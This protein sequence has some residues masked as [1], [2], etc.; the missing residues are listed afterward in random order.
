MKQFVLFFAVIFFIFMTISVN[1]QDRFDRS[2][3]IVCD[4]L[5]NGGMG[6]IVSGVDFDNDG[7]ME[8]YMVNNNWNDLLGHEQVP[9]IYKYEK[10]ENGEWEVVWSTRLPLNYQNTWP[11]LD[12]GD[13]D[14]DGKM[15]VIWGP[16][17]ND[18]SGLQPVQER[19]LVFETPGDG[20]DN[21]GVQDPAT[22]YWRPNA[23]WTITTTPLANIRPFRWIVADVD[24][25]GTQEIVAECRAGDFMQIYSVD[26][27]PDAADSTETWTLEFS[28]GTSDYGDLAIIGN[29]MYFMKYLTGD[30]IKVVATA[31]NT[32]EIADTLVGVAG[33][34]TWKS[35]ATV[36]VD[37][38]GT[39][40][41]ILVSYTPSND[42]YLLQEDGDTLIST[43]IKDV[44]TSSNRSQG[45]AAG[46]LDDDGNLDFVFGTRQS[47]PLGIIH[48]L[49]Y[50]GGVITDPNN[51][52]LSI[53]D[54]GLHTSQQYDVISVGNLDEDPEDEV[55]Y[56]ALPR[57]LGVSDSPA[58]V[59]VLDLIPE[60]QPIISAIAD[61][62]NDQG[63]Q[64]WVIWQAAGEDISDGESIIPVALYGPKGVEFPEIY[65]NGK[66]LVPIKG[67][68][69]PNTEQISQYVVW[70]IDAGTYPVQVASVVPIQA[71]YYAAVVPTL[72]DGMEEWLT[73][74]IVSSH[75]PD[76]LE[77]W[78]SFPKS[79]YSVDNLIPTAPLN[80]TGNVVN[81]NVEL[82]WDE[83]PDPDFN[84]FSIRR[85][86][87]TGFDPTL[88]TEIGTTT[89][90]TYVDENVGTGNFFY[91]VVAYDFN[92]NQGEFSAEL[93]IVITGI[94]NENAIPKEF[95]L[96]Q[97]YPNPFNPETWIAFDLPKAVNVTIVIYNTLGQKVRTLVDEP[98]AAGS[99][100]ILWNGTNDQ[101]NNVASGV[102]VYSIKAGS[103]VQAK[104]M[105]L[106]R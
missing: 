50:Q 9:R 64:V 48:R 47:T 96:R 79:G 81:S 11:A 38:D 49:E 33:T 78:K 21:M 5:D 106:M 27:V 31:P 3:E 26:D 88:A 43:K 19:V 23:Q 92:A 68:T 60:N 80:L 91:R 12:K 66:L 65:I 69:L 29:R 89:A 15:E 46:D 41:I 52:E 77:N 45:G 42:V 94:G 83:S 76:P 34:G 28:A 13:L 61:V 55:V 35:A 93:P 36:D 101:G 8:I 37:N 7:A 6:Y 103:F 58:P 71:P 16:V 39:E 90:N 62:P 104:K 4:T 1:A 85:G 20:S 72:G 32:Y 102:Y 86:T 53:I 70:R 74:F 40:E 73:D 24:N 82:A 63:R 14:N 105:T 97:N 56:T 57:G 98:T 100:K 18:G 30:V 2:A 67:N 59:A 54:Q 10:N 25:D 99:Y 44:P 75:T 95:A 22:G 17:N 51:W 87:E 84:Y